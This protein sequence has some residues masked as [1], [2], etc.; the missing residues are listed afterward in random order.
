MFEFFFK[1]TAVFIIAIISFCSYRASENTPY[2]ERKISLDSPDINLFYPIYDPL[3]P[4][5]FSQG[6]IDFQMPLNINNNVYYDPVSGQYVFN[7]ILGDS[8]NFRPSSEISL[9]D[10]IKIQHDQS[11]QDFWKKKIG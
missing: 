6:L 1:K 8:L 4:T 5:N 11:M 2:N 9:K 7:S 3:D 10:Y